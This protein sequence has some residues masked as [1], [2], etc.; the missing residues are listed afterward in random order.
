MQKAYKDLDIQFLPDSILK[1][2]N[3]QALASNFSLTSTSLNI[4]ESSINHFLPTEI[5]SINNLVEL[6]MGLCYVNLIE[7]NF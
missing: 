7:K 6:D 2:L 1:G 3:Q 4:P 5:L